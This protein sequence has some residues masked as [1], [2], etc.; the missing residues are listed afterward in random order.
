MTPTAGALACSVR[1]WTIALPGASQAATPFRPILGDEERDRAARFHRAADRDRY[2]T[3]H[4]ALRLILA[5]CVAA[6]PAGLRFTL[7]RHGKPALV[8]DFYCNGAQNY[9]ELAKEVIGKMEGK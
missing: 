2:V 9:L 3:A 6:D 8:Y 5:D 1:V 4:G 7:A